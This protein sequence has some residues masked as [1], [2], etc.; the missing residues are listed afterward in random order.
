MSAATLERPSTIEDVDLAALIGQAPPCEAERAKH[1]DQECSGNVT[2]RLVTCT[3]R[4]LVCDVAVKQ[5]REAMARGALC[6]QHRERIDAVW[7]LIPV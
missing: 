6:D 2:H 5:L 3:R 7:R 1:G 4:L